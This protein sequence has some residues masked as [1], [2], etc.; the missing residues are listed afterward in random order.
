MVTKLRYGNTNT[1]FVRGKSGNVL[2]D[3]D[4]AGMLPIFYKEMK[5]NQIAMKD[6]T[7]FLAT[8]YHPDHIGLA[9][10]LMKQGVL[11]LLM[12]SQVGMTHFSD[13]IFARQPRLQYEP[14]TEE[15]AK[16]LRFAESRDFLR[17]LGIEGEIIS[18][19]SHSA[20]SI[21]V[22]LDEGVAIVGDLEPISFLNAY[23]ENLKLKQDWESIRQYHPKVVYYAHANENYF[24]E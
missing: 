11:L 7:Y 6:I 18:T 14:I 3:T 12:E 5:Q 8:H 1:F 2:I 21:S 9:S 15:K 17:S 24:D 19:P 23:E 4:Y 22:V 10:E 16:I 20:D 13:E